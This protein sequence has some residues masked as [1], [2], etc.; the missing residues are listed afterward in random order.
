MNFKTRQ[1]AISDKEWLYKLYCSTMRTYI[2]QTWGWDEGYQKNCLETNLYPTKFRIVIV[3][4][5]DVGAYLINQ[6]NNYYW[7]E[8]LLISK[9]MQGKGLGTAIIKTIQ[10]QT[11]NDRKPLKLSVLKVNPAK[12]FYSRL[13]FCVYDQDESFFKMKWTYNKPTQTMQKRRS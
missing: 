6:E 13:G 9:K 4:N 3:N 12:K 8:M 1:G 7:L 10:A 5:N 11:E 2:E